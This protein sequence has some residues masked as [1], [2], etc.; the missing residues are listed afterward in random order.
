MCIQENEYVSRLIL[1]NIIVT[2]II[3]KIY[4]TFSIKVLTQKLIQFKL[5][6]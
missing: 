2:H 5:K 1:I 3:Y 4:H 6:Y